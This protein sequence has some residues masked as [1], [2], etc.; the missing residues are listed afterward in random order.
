MERKYLRSKYWEGLEKLLQKRSNRAANRLPP[1]QSR[2]TPHTLRYC[3]SVICKSIIRTNAIRLKVVQGLL[4]FLGFKGEI[5]KKRIHKNRVR[6][7]KKNNHDIH[8]TVKRTREKKNEE[9]TAE[10]GKGKGRTTQLHLS[11]KVP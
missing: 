3:G 11:Y 7:K 10:K 8:K 1:Q 6:K 5:Q 4:A 2:G 9:K